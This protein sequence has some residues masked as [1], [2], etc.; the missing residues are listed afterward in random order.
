MNIL[1][2]TD[3]AAMVICG[4]FGTLRQARYA[5]YD[6]ELQDDMGPIFAIALVWHG[7]LRERIAIEDLP[8]Q[9]FLYVAGCFA[10]CVLGEFA[11]V[12]AY[13]VMPPFVHS[14]GHDSR[15]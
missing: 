9:L 7:L 14:L 5:E 10:A 8:I 1:K 3:H 6:P 13:Q 15:W 12:H 4:F 2:A 11:P